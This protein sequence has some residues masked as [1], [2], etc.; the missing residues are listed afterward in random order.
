M[1]EGRASK[2]KQRLGIAAIAIAVIAA[3]SFIARQLNVL[4]DPSEPT[5]DGMSRISALSG[6]PIEDETERARYVG[7]Q[8]E[9]SDVDVAHDT[10]PDG[11]GGVVVIGGLLKVAGRVHNKGERA[12]RAARLKL[13]LKDAEGKVIGTYFNEVVGKT[14]L[15]GGESRP[16]KFTVPEKKEYGGTFAYQLE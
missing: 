9:V 16:F 8:V 7:A 6:G 1:S 13:Y 5:P 12:I 11:D 14:P 3:A 2:V 15:K 4:E 10:Q